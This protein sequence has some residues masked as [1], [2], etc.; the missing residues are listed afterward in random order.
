MAGTFGFSPP[1]QWRGE[2]VP[3]SDIYAL[4]ATLHMLVSGFQPTLDRGDLPEFLRGRKVAFPPARSVN[5]AVPAAVEALIARGLAFEPAQRPSAAELLAA[6]E[7]LLAPRARAD[8]QSPDGVALADESALARWAEQHW[9]VAAGWLYGGLADQV[10]RLWGKNR[11]AGDLRALVSRHAADQHAGLDELLA[12]LDPAGFGAASPRLTADRRAINF[13]QL[14]MSDRRDAAIQLTNAGRRYVRVEIQ[15][16]RWVIASTPSIALPPGQQQRLRLTADMRRAGE[17]GHLRGAVLLR[18]RS[19]AGFRVEVEAQ[20]SRWRALWQ[21]T[22]G[23]GGAR[24]DWESG[25]VRPLR[26]LDAHRGGAWGIDFSPD[27]RQLASGGWDQCVRLWRVRD[28]VAEGRLDDQ[29]G[30]VLA[31]AYSPDGRLLATAGNSEL[32]RLWSLHDR[33]PAQTI[34]AH[35]NYLESVH[36]SADGQLLITCGGDGQVAIWRVSDGSLV[37]RLAPE[38]R[39]QLLAC[40]PEGRS[41]ALAGADRLVRLWDVQANALIGPLSGHEAGVSCLAYSRDGGLLASG[42]NNGAICLWDL[43]AGALRISLRGHESGVRCLAI[44]PDGQLVA[45]GGVD[46]SI[47]LWRSG[48]GAPLH[49]L[50]GHS[51]GVLRLVFSAAGDLLAS[52]GGDGTIRLWQPG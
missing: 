25:D 39:P 47:R 44:H 35:R 16:P 20:I 40:H 23:S 46:G 22:I 37:Q 48:D 30:N 10:A 19:G 18:D 34:S 29:G 8:L 43:D 41:L 2:S 6:L 24:Y 5:P 7:R 31:V 13:G 9:A 17:G 49:V 26:T 52:G 38:P 51:S 32:L 21:R 11:L 12:I 3:R 36:F 15:T 4:C 27:G 45:S 1:E 33:R 42:D 14:D 28:G 50:T